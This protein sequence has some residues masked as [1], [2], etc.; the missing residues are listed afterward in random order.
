MSPD[1]YKVIDSVQLRVAMEELIADISG[2]LV[3][4]T[5]INMTRCEVFASLWT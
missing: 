3:R 5:S 1:G 2:V 4:L